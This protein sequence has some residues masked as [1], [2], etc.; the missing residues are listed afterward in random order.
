MSNP[1]IQHRFVFLLKQLGVAV[2]Y[3]LLIF[4][5]HH[6][7]ESATAVSPFEAA[8]GFALAVMLIGRKRMYGACSS[9]LFDKTGTVLAARMV[10]NG[11][12]M[13]GEIHIRFC[14]GV[15]MRFSCA[16]T[17]SFKNGQ[18]SLLPELSCFSRNVFKSIKLMV[19]ATSRSSSTP[20][21][22]ETEK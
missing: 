5:D 12:R 2:L 17:T 10:S 6:Y 1:D 15:E 11:S 9:A 3:A 18:L 22:C 14:G 4:L 16:L 7:F 21:Y 19:R 20:G 8:S 13:N